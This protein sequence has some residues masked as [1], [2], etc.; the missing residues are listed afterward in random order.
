MALTAHD[1]A[2]TCLCLGEHHLVASGDDE[3]C[4]IV[5]N[6]N[7]AHVVRSHRCAGGVRQLLWL[8]R[9]AIVALDS[10]G[11]VFIFGPNASTELR[12][13]APNVA[14][15]R[16]AVHV[17]IVQPVGGGC[18]VSVAHAD[19]STVA[20]AAKPVDRPNEWTAAAILAVPSDPDD[21]RAP[22]QSADDISDIDAHWGTS[23]WLVAARR[24]IAKQVQQVG[25][26]VDTQ[27]RLLSQAHILNADCQYDDE[28]TESFFGPKA[29]P[30]VVAPTLA[31]RL[32]QPARSRH[33]GSPTLARSAG[34]ANDWVHATDSLLVR[35]TRRSVLVWDMHQAGSSSGD[36]LAPS[37]AFDSRR[38]ISWLHALCSSSVLVRED[39]INILVAGFT[40]GSVAAWNV[41]NGGRIWASRHQDHHQGAVIGMRVIRSATP[42]SAVSAA[43]D[44]SVICWTMRG[45]QLWSHTCPGPLVA[46]SL[47]GGGESCR[48]VAVNT[49]GLA[50]FYSA[51]GTPVGSV[52]CDSLACSAMA[53]VPNAVFAVK[54]ATGDLAAFVSSAGRL[55]QVWS[56]EAAVSASS[57]APQL[58]ATRERVFIADQA[59]LRCFACRGGAEVW[60]SLPTD[61]HRDAIGCVVCVPYATPEGHKIVLTSDE[62]D[63]RCWHQQT[64]ALLALISLPACTF[65]VVPSGLH[66]TAEGTVAIG[67]SP[68]TEQVFG[69]D[70]RL[71]VVTWSVHLA[72]GGGPWSSCV[73]PLGADDFG[74]VILSGANFTVLSA[75]GD[76]VWQGAVDRHMCVDGPQTG[77]T[78]TDG[79]SPTP[80]AGWLTL[81]ATETCVAAISAQHRLY[82]W[83]RSHDNIQRTWASVTVPAMN[84]PS[85]QLWS[86]VTARGDR[87]YA[88][89]RDGAMSCINVS[90][91]ELEFR[92]NDD[93]VGTVA[94]SILGRL[95]VVACGKGIS[96]VDIATFQTLGTE[97][98]H[99]VDVEGNL[100]YALAQYMP[101][102]GMVQEAL[103]VAVQ[104][105]QL[106]KFAFREATPTKL[107]PISS[108]LDSLSSFGVPSMSYA[109]A[110]VGVFVTL[111]LLFGLLSVSENVETCARRRPSSK[112]A[113]LCWL[114]VQQILGFGCRA[115]FLPVVE[116][117]AQPFDCSQLPGT[118]KW[119]LDA[120]PDTECWVD[121]GHVVHAAFAVLFGALFGWLVVRLQLCGGSPAALSFSWL[122]L[123]DRDNDAFHARHTHPMSPMSVAYRVTAALVKVV[124][125]LTVLLL[126]SYDGIVA[127][128]AVACGCFL[129]AASWF[130][131]Q[132]MPSTGFPFP[133]QWETMVS[134]VTV[135]RAVL[136]RVVA[137]RLRC[138]VDGGMLWTYLCGAAFVLWQHEA[139]AIE[140]PLLY[141]P[142]VFLL[143]L[144]ATSISLGRRLW[145]RRHRWLRNGREDHVE[146]PHMPLVLLADLVPPTIVATG[147]TDSDREG[148]LVRAPAWRSRVLLTAWWQQVMWRQRPLETPW[149]NCRMVPR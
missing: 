20:W 123:F 76:I 13:H 135:R 2:V 101:V 78:A 71:S 103:V 24:Q 99:F 7:T 120:A 41:A 108:S 84:Q 32:F 82:V 67:V 27:Q 105:G 1:D 92:T 85:P 93:F 23:P 69:L 6:G 63:T 143:V 117:L 145:T 48:I 22:L 56:A 89:A 52:Q 65:V 96:T 79:A 127:A 110:Q 104:L 87:V 136:R 50:R 66:D 94:V 45:Q 9:N 37:V 116:L 74:V 90:T 107:K 138:I 3:G 34:A 46:L 11:R 119:V 40:D 15:R 111:L 19:G 148:E 35:A 88:V 141:A 30:A 54:Q 57:T 122:R 114:L 147:E 10:T 130:V 146:D 80:N 100:D 17:C 64:G 112:S 77:S 53:V 14:P 31:K 12:Q 106:A 140:W 72:A 102:V 149:C 121:A 75:A 126:G 62:R 73:C 125:V 16:D 132:Y 139:W 133:A 98:V 68:T 115:L 26:V 113:A 118:G 36:A 131:P 137:N 39:D 144:A 95:A 21:A 60:S 134:Q 61:Q 25:S 109:S 58:C 29:A 4:V 33:S 70:S 44:G 129:L 97:V 83:A 51:A 55:R 86:A 47:V 81:T 42:W 28:E 49:H 8:G 128:V 124:L 142:A 59:S 18:L 43:S 38:I 91:C 5:W